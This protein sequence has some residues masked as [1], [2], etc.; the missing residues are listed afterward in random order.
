M[1]FSKRYG[2][3]LFSIHNERYLYQVDI[4]NDDHV[5]PLDFKV[6]NWVLY[7]DLPQSNK[8]AWFKILSTTTRHENFANFAIGLILKHLK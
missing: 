4:W 2:L 8:T 6:F 5:L 7:R 3:V 1:F